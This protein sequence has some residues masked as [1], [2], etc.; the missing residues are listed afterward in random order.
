M[1]INS[2]EF[3]RACSKG[4]SEIDQFVK[5][6]PDI[7]KEFI[8][9]CFL[10]K[11]LFREADVSK[12]LLENYHDLIEVNDNVIKYAFEDSLEFAKRLWELSDKKIEITNKLFC[13]ACSTYNAN[14]DV[15]KW[16]YSL[17]EKKLDISDCRF[18]V[19]ATCCQYGN[20]DV[21]KW[22]F[23]TFPETCND[24]KESTLIAICESNDVELIE[25]FTSVVEIKLTYKYCY[26]YDSIGIYLWLQKKGIENEFNL[27]QEIKECL[28]YGR[29]CVKILTYIIFT[30]DIPSRD[31]RKHLNKIMKDSSCRNITDFV[32]AYRSNYYGTLKDKYVDILK[33]Y[34][35]RYFKSIHSDTVSSYDLMFESR[36]YLINYRKSINKIKRA[37]LE[38]LYSPGGLYYMVAC[39]AFKG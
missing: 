33:M 18:L 35:R 13:N 30:R 39:N 14:L 3:N 10:R 16:L 32:A 31:F 25:W 1:K 34:I 28:I 21:A 37:F 9:S 15:I 8:N 38:R 5:D 29:G 22:L 27:D 24:K 11:L 19:F 17:S 20:V 36:K 7:K 23:K 2:P 12:Y 26:W 6:Y 4:I